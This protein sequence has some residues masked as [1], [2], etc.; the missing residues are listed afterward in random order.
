[1]AY[2]TTEVLE[3]LLRQAALDD[4]IAEARTKEVRFALREIVQKM[5][6]YGISLNELVGRKQ[7]SEGT[8]IQAK[9]RD[10]ASGATWSGNALNLSPT[11]ASIKRPCTRDKGGVWPFWVASDKSVR[12]VCGIG[13][14]G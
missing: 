12:A 3:L 5:R 4:A 7:E 13:S 11:S 10:P 9:Y 2:S 14:G 8:N 1:M 6:E